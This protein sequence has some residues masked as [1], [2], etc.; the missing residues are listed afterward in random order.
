MRPEERVVVAR[1]TDPA[2][3]SRRGRVPTGSTPCSAAAMDDR[4][5]CDLP[6]ARPRGRRH[7]PQRCPS[8]RQ[9]RRSSSSRRSMQVPRPGT[10]RPRRR[11]RNGLDRSRCVRVERRRVGSADAGPVGRAGAEPRAVGA[12]LSTLR[13]TDASG[14][15]V[16]LAALRGEDRRPVGHAHAVPGHVPDRHCERRRDGPAGQRC[17]SG[18]STS[19]SSASQSTRAAMS[20]RAWRPIAASTRRHRPTGTCSPGRRRE[21]NLFWDTLG[22]F[23]KREADPQ[24]GPKD[25][26]TGSPAH[27]R[28][29]AFGR[30]VL[31]RPDRPGAVLA[32]GPATHLAR[33]P[34]AAVLKK[35]IAA[36]DEGPT[37]SPHGWST[38][39]AV[40]VL[41]WLL[42]KRI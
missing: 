14:R 28:R 33:Q 37:S 42:D 13:L 10:L 8:P 9:D 18:W 39:Q 26:L 16:S 40:Q 27:L 24:P 29:H 4:G 19:H 22:V 17:R 20:P 36:G 32:A 21:I 41:A 2:G 1:R 3:R 34:G 23:R 35:F 31:L 30:G 11:N 7:R 15:A 25:W 38:D 6:V 12:R 5:W